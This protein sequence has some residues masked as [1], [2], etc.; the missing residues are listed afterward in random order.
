MSDLAAGILSAPEVAESAETPEVE[1]VETPEGET[2]EGEASEGETPEGETPE[3]PKVPAKLNAAQVR[4]SL[5]ALREANPND[6]KAI[7][8]AN[9]ALGRAE[10]FEK[11]YPKRVVDG[12]TV[13]GV[14]EAQAVKTAVDAAGGL[15]GIAKYQQIVSS[16]EETDA[17]LEAGDGEV[18]KQIREDA[19]EGYV[20]LLVPYLSD[21]AENNPKE[22]A[23]AVQPH[24]IRSLAAAGLPNSLQGLLA[25][26]AANDLPGAK[27]IAEDMSNWFNEQRRLAEASGSKE[28]DPERKK[29]ADEWTKVNT[30]KDKIFNSTVGS[31]VN[32]HVVTSF[33]SAMEPYIKNHPSLT[34]KQRTDIGTSLVNTLGQLLNK[35][36]AYMREMKRL[37]TGKNRNTATA[38]DFAKNAVNA[39]ITDV[40]NTVVKQYG[41]KK[42]TAKAAPKVGDKGT[43]PVTP[44]VGTLGT[45][46]N[47]I[48]VT[49]KPDRSLWDMAKTSEDMIIRGQAVLKS[50][51]KIVTWR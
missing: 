9:D 27:A 30:E 48:R 4:Q 31:T 5:K 43:P 20:K 18:L 36:S 13:G 29:V 8:F 11:L 14:S 51:G 35:D 50:N 1:V 7:Q 25:K 2:P 46:S 49:S 16:V 39:L 6:A 26:I 28:I 23:A 22:F 21:M 41:L 15:D 37:T 44:K 10:A 34:P 47:P 33:K 19:P 40:V 12:R 42:A 17:L 3:T 24:M 38:S 45:A 32:A